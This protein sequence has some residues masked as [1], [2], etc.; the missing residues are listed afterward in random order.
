MKRY[1]FLFEQ[2]FSLESLYQ[3]WLD[4]SRSKMGKRAC[5]AFG[6]QL[7]A[8]LDALHAELR[9][10]CY[11]PQPYIEFEVYE[12]KRRTIYAPAFRDLVVQHAIYRLVYPIFDRGFIDQSFACRLGRGTHKAA[13]YA[14][15][16]LRHSPPGAHTL[17]MDVRKFFYRI[18]RAILQTLLARKI[19]DQRFLAV[20][21][22]FADHGQPIGIP[23]GNLLSQLYALVYLDPLD[24]FIKRELRARS[25]CRYVDDFVIFGWSASDCRAALEKVKA[26]LASR[27]SLELSKF[28]IEPLARGINF[29]GYRMW[30]KTRFIRKHSLRQFSCAAKKSKLQSVI[31]ILGHARQTGS[32]RHLLTTL[33]D[34]HHD[35]FNRLPKTHR[36]HLHPRAAAAS[37]A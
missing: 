30:R 2:A 27:L 5:L 16:A 23:I 34:N 28:S 36:R 21:M 18:D 8:N 24:Q 20:M 10:G 9:S 17:K 32:F 19:K 14:Q 11:R 12:P 15:A 35:L 33:K 37:A 22:Q 31:S 6:R 25:Y 13:D 1:G 3:A 4:A 29:V 26:F 7:A